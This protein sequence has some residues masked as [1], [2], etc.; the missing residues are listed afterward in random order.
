[1]YKPSASFWSS[2]LV[3][4]L[5]LP[6]F[7]ALKMSSFCLS[8]RSSVFW[9]LPPS[10]SQQEVGRFSLLTMI[11]LHLCVFVSARQPQIH[12]T[13]EQQQILSHDIQPDHV[14][15]IV[16]FA[17]TLAPF[18]IMPVFA[19]SDFYSSHFPVMKW[20]KCIH[21]WSLVQWI[22]YYRWTINFGGY[23][24]FV[25]IIFSA[26]WPHNF[27]VI[28]IDSD[29]LLF[30]G[31]FNRAWLIHHLDS[32]TSTIK[33]KYKALIIDLKEPIIDLNKSGMSLE[34]LPKQLQV[35]RSKKNRKLFSVLRTWGL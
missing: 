23:T 14:V 12:L 29:W 31:H 6:R 21:S 18:Y 1:M 35:P 7:R 28:L 17:G 2:A 5:F 34:A 27:W 26:A 24:K 13:S 30:W 16:A 25:W 22:M 9:Q 15:K 3:L 32:A 19:S 10:L 20:E 4:R 8:G 11:I 33:G